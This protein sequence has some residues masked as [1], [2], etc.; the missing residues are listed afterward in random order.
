MKRIFIPTVTGSDWQRLLAQPTR[1]WKKGKS[2][3]TAAAAWENEGDS[4]PPE[5]PALLDSSRD[6]DLVG[7]K[8]LAAIPEW[9][10]PLEGGDTASH[11]DILA[12]VG[13]TE[14]CVSSPSKRR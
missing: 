1:H 5:I 14:A 4:L 7:L 6:E 3:M 8:L 13:T 12:S 9:E 10:V 11:S 2:A